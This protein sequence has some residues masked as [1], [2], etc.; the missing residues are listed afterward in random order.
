MNY[1]FLILFLI[2]SLINIIASEKEFQL[3]MI[4][5]KITLAPLAFL[6]LLINTTFSPL[7]TTLLNIAYLFY[8]LG[9]IFLLSKSKLFFIVGLLNFIFGHITFIIVFLHFSIN[10]WIF[11]IALIALIFPQIYIFKLTDQAG[12]LKTPMRLYSILLMLFIAFSSITLNLV[13]ILAT[14]LFTI[15]DSMIAR[16]SCFGKRLHSHTQIMGTYSAAIILLSIGMIMLS[17]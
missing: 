15:S 7:I 13:L 3:I 16:N 14:S 8:L 2:I 6:N 5:S 9:D 4:L 11:P 1:I 10:Y 12:E 17:L